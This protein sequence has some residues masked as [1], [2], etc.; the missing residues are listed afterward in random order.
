MPLYIH[1]SSKLTATKDISRLIATVLLHCSHYA[2]VA[3][4]I[5]IGWTTV[6]NDHAPNSRSRKFAASSTA[7]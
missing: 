7:S 5:S 1:F 3:Y 4:S 2:P 6:T